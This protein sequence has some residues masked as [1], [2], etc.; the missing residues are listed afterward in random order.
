MRQSVIWVF[1][2]WYMCFCMVFLIQRLLQRHNQENANIGSCKLININ[3]IYMFNVKVA[4]AHK[5]W[6][7]SAKSS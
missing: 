2:V 1:V 3:N 6:F 5:M 7:P 4:F